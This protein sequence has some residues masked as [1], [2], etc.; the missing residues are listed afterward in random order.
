MTDPKM[1]GTTMKDLIGRK[2]R[3]EKDKFGNYQPVKELASA[4]WQ[5]PDGTVQSCDML[6]VK[7]EIPKKG[8]IS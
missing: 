5:H 4:T 8:C 2:F 1:T 6:E 7:S 3:F